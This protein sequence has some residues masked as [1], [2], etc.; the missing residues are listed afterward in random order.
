MH[1]LLLL[2]TVQVHCIIKS[3][4]WILEPFAGAEEDSSPLQFLLNAKGE[5][6][7]EPSPQPPW[8]FQ[9]VCTTKSSRVQAGLRTGHT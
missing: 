1:C 5:S 3:E 6:E 4:V 2:H 8:P 9:N 7:I